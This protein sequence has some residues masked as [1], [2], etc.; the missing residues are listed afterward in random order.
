VS[1]NTPAKRNV[2]KGPARGY[3][4]APFENGNRAALKHAVYLSK[5]N[6]DERAEVEE[7]ADALR[8]ALPV[9]SPS[10]EPTLRMCAARIWRWRRAYR[11]PS[12]RGEDASRGLLRDLNTLERSLQRDFDSLGVSPRAAAELGVSLTKL[13]AVSED[14]APPFDWNA[15]EQRERRTLER[16]LAKGRRAAENGDGA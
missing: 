6:D 14:D 2:G 3:S 4:W 1:A 5:F 11:Y 9:Y 15:L 16:L 8:D 12:E 7:I 10:F 13:A